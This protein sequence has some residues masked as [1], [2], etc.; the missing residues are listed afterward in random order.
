MSCPV[1]PKH[2]HGPQ[3]AFLPMGPNGEV[4]PNPFPWP[5]PQ[6]GDIPIWHPPIRPPSPPKPFNPMDNWPVFP[7]RI[8]SPPPAPV[9]TRPFG[10]PI[11]R[12]SSSQVVDV[13]PVSTSDGNEDPSNA[14]TGAPPAGAS[15]ISS[16]LNSFRFPNYDNG[17]G[18]DS[19]SG[20]SSGMLPSGQKVNAALLAPV[21]PVPAGGASKHIELPPLTQEKSLGTASLKRASPAPSSLAAKTSIESKKSKG[22]GKAR[23]KAKELQERALKCLKEIADRIRKRLSKTKNKMRNKKKEKTD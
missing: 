21:E 12:L 22:S 10:Q 5:C 14:S 23:K 8:P 15:S 13:A 17:D 18:S 1:N 19:T 4:V 9:Y 11:S 16:S 7:S 20:P 2:T 3:P 6:P